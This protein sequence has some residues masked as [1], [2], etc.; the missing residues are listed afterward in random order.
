MVWKIF[1]LD[2]YSPAYS[3]EYHVLLWNIRFSSICIY[4]HGILH[5]SY[6]I[7]LHGFYIK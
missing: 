1:V 7:L 3:D 2:L 6:A 5:Y 4:D